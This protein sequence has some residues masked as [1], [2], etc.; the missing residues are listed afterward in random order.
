MEH[1]KRLDKWVVEHYEWLRKEISTNIAKN[2]MS[3][4]ADDLLH[5]QLS[6]LYR[7]E[8][9]KLTQ[10]LD[11]GKLKWY[12]LTCAGLSLR[13]KTT[14]FYRIYRKEKMNSREHGL[15][16]SD[17][18]I[19]EREYEPYKDDLYECFQREMNNLHWYQKTLM[20]KYWIEGWNL[21]KM[22]K[23]YNISKQHLVNDLNSAMDTIR[24]NCK[25]C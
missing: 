21:T 6:E 25:D 7:M 11:D 5:H 15:P 23:H 12:L 22:Y 19:F 18:N 13:S 3:E 20:D 17:K 2:Q 8:A 1:K 4:Y 9:G 24:E 10:M 14:P 16:G